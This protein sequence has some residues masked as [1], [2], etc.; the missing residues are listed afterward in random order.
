M[1]GPD[2]TGSLNHIHLVI[3]REDSHVVWEERENWT[4]GNG[5]QLFQCLLYF[6]AKMERAAD[7]MLQ[8]VKL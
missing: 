5:V 1:G 4:M 8:F 3:Y 6:D 7:G 2:G